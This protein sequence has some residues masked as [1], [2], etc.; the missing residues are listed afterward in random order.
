MERGSAG[1]AGVSPFLGIPL[2]APIPQLRDRRR[3]PRF[4]RVGSGRSRPLCAALP[5]PGL[6]AAAEP[7]SV[8]KG[9]KPEP[10]LAMKE[11]KRTKSWELQ[12]GRPRAGVREG[13]S[14]AVWERA[15]APGGG[16][17]RGR[18]RPGHAWVGAAPWAPQDAPCRR[19]GRPRRA[20]PGR[21][22]GSGGGASAA[23]GY[24][25]AGTDGTGWTES[26]GTALGGAEGVLSH[27]SYGCAAP[28]GGQEHLSPER[29]EGFPSANDPRSAE[30][31]PSSLTLSRGN[32][33][34]LR[35]G[36]WG[37]AALRF[38]PVAALGMNA[39]LLLSSRRFAA[40][41]LGPRRALVSHT[42]VA[43]A[44]RELSPRARPWL[45]LSAGTA[46]RSRCPVLSVLGVTEARAAAS[47]PRALLLT[48]PF[49]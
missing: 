5:V 27:R 18:G 6:S 15:A 38:S 3:T 36:D 25:R 10:G 9:Q 48:V 30:K 32:P 22:Y 39:P 4:R 45:R 35:A 8:P 2:A 1:R 40:Q 11:P 16:E 20:G 14:A 43:P 31:S 21:S 47:L 7:S 44:P 41:P 34:R 42:R 46:R 13:E 28:R 29:R 23:A 17:R 24:L 33:P 37:G 12:P 49:E 19:G 26:T